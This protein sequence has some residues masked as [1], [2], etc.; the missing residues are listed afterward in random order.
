M[1]RRDF[2]FLIGG[3][4]IA[5]SRAANAQ[6]AAT[7]KIGYLSSIGLEEKGLSAFRQGLA[8]FGY[9]EGKN[10]SIEYR[11]A[12]GNYDRLSAFAAELA[13]LP[14]KLIVAAP[15]SPAPAA[16]KKVTS[17]IPI[18]F[19]IG[20]DPVHLGLVESYSRPG[21]NMTGVSTDSEQLT[22]RRFQLLLELL[23]ATA[24]IAFLTNP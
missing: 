8:E 9:V 12:D 19:F 3:A 15:S 20:G 13:S 16:L 21:A 7:P 14:V 17:A 23:P 18:V 10:I 6:Q 1:R 5:R 4:A 24:L 11:H 22:Q 2:I